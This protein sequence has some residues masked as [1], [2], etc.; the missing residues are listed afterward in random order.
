MF[1]MKIQH[2]N[3]VGM[4]EITEKHN[5]STLTA[6]CPSLPAIYAIYLQRHNYCIR[7]SGWL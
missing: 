5:M 4:T 2:Y 3:I 6:G 1:N 7:C